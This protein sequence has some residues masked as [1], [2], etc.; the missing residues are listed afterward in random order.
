VIHA[1]CVFCVASAILVT[2]TFLVAV[3]EWRNR[4]VATTG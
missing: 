4:P 1:I 3:L 2:V